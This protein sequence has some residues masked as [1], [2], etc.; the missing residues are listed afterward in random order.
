MSLTQDEV[1]AL[2]GAPARIDSTPVQIKWRY[3][4]GTA[5]FDIDTKRFVGYDR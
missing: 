3:P 5:Y 2:L 1:R 4:C